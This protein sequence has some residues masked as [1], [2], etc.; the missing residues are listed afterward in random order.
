MDR[1]AK[2]VQAV[3][4]LAGPVDRVFERRDP[5]KTRTQLAA[6][7]ERVQALPAQPAVQL[8]RRRSV[9]AGVAQKNVEPAVA[10]HSASLSSR[11][12][13]V[14]VTSCSASSASSIEHGRSKRQGTMY[15]DMGR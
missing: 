2:G 5:A 13:R 7:K 4:L 11:R 3:I 14:Q 10:S 12:R 9:A 1:P 15:S 8:R 6:V